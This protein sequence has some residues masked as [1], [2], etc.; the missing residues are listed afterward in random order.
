[1]YEETHLY[2]PLLAFGALWQAPVDGWMDGGGGWIVADDG[3]DS[4]IFL[5]LAIISGAGRGAKVNNVP[6]RLG[7]YYLGS[8]EVGQSS[9]I[10]YFIIFHW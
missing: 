9:C 5:I 4:W 10:Q 8:K 1:M 6:P 2:G 7:R 3:D